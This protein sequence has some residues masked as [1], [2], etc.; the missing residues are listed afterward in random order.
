MRYL[1]P[2]SVIGDCV[3]AYNRSSIPTYSMASWPVGMSAVLVWSLYVHGHNV[4]CD[5]WTPE[6][7]EILSLQNEPDNTHYQF[8]VA[9]IKNCADVGHNPKAVSRIVF[10]FLDRDCHTGICEVIGNCLNLM[11]GVNLGVEVPCI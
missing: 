3:C 7:G 6:V 1:E 2:V 11:H 5:I 4:Y 10:H 8:S 9:V